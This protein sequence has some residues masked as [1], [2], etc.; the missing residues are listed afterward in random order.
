ML[1]LWYLKILFKILHSQARILGYS[2]KGKTHFVQKNDSCLH[3]QY[4]EKWEHL[5]ASVAAMKR[6]IYTDNSLMLMEMSYMCVHV[7]MCVCTRVLLYASYLKCSKKFYSWTMN[8]VVWIHL[9]K[10]RRCHSCC[11]L[12][13]TYCEACADMVS[14]DE[15]TPKNLISKQNRG[16]FVK[17]LASINIVSK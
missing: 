4:C 17:N 16:S 7:C 12:I 9:D 11:N 13:H 3:V 1:I 14:C 2:G 8:A 10:H 15:D 6:V 5:P